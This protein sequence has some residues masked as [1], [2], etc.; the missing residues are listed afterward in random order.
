[1]RE[2]PSAVPTWSR[3]YSR[4]FEAFIVDQATHDR[5]LWFDRLSGDECR[6]SAEA[7]GCKGANEA[8]E[9]KEGNPFYDQVN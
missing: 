7:H 3:L 9:Q 2:Q 8:T 5:A 4:S 1:V 6:D